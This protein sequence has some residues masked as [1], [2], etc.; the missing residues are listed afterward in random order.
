MNHVDGVPVQP[1][2]QAGGSRVWCSCCSA[3]LPDTGGP[4]VAECPNCGA[5]VDWDAATKRS[6]A[7]TLLQQA[8]EEH[9]EAQH[10]VTAASARLA[11]ARQDATAAYWA[12]QSAQESWDALQRAARRATPRPARCRGR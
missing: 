4:R 6:R 1:V 9:R 5:A 12:R 11:T 3:P 7:W 8:E 10:R 2:E